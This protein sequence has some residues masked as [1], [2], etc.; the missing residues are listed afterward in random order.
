MSIS[1]QRVVSVSSS[2]SLGLRGRWIAALVAGFAALPSM[3]EAKII[4]VNCGA[5]QTIQQ[6]LG[7]ALPGDVIQVS[8]ACNENVLVRESRNEVTLEGGGLASIQGPDT[9]RATVTVRGRGITIRRFTITGGQNGVQV[10][11]GGSAVID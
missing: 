1:M 11:D 5:G 6:A 9:S 8:G 7:F 10:Q 4:A 3:V 2:A